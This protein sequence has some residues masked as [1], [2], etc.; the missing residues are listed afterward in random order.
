MSDLARLAQGL[1]LAIHADASPGPGLSAGVRGLLDAVCEAAPGPGRDAAK[2]LQFLRGLGEQELA[3][4]R[5]RRGGAR[6]PE[7]AGGRAGAT[8]P[9]ADAAPQGAAAPWWYA[10]PGGFLREFCDEVAQAGREAARRPWTFA[11][12]AR[13]APA[14]DDG[15]MNASRLEAIV[16]L[17]LGAETDEELERARGQAQAVAAMSDQE[18]LALAQAEGRS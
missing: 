2:L 12:A 5:R 4:Q 14:P 3:R 9:G 11:R 15:D 16:R 6:R 18:V 17:L 13:G 7:A 10:R 8:A 1:L